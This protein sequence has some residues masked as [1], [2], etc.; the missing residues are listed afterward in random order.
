MSA[1][2]CGGSDPRPDRWGRNS[3]QACLQPG[4]HGVE[5]FFRRVVLDVLVGE[6]G[7]Q[8]LLVVP[9]LEVS[10]STQY[11]TGPIGFDSRLADEPVAELPYR[12]LE[13]PSMNLDIATGRSIT[14][15]AVFGIGVYISGVLWSV[16][17]RTRLTPGRRGS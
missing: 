6:S 3:I 11:P 1:A 17:V 10:I 4:L 8:L 15:Q 12:L 13:I 5:Q 14:T 2:R 9:F 16:V 7:S